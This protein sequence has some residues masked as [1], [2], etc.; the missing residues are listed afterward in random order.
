[1]EA[2]TTSSKNSLKINV[3]MPPIEETRQTLKKI[4]DMFDYIRLDLDTPIIKPALEKFDK[5]I[6]IKK[7]CSTN[8]LQERFNNHMKKL[9]KIF[10]DSLS[11]IH[12]DRRESTEDLVNGVKG[13]YERLKANGYELSKENLEDFA[14]TEINLHY[15]D[16]K[17]YINNFNEGNKRLEYN[18][19]QKIKA[20]LL[21][22][23][24]FNISLQKSLCD[25]IQNFYEKN[26][27]LLDSIAPD[28]KKVLNP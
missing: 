1:M 12:H 14:N 9:V 22:S 5:F 19:L 20:I 6:E 24:E 3:K 16:L 13:L 25:S 15:N 21:I 4:D 17:W 18:I 28:I 10:E 7:L 26:S 23:K 2:I 27:E 11:R 8:E